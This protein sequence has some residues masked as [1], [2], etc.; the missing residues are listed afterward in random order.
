MSVGEPDR[1]TSLLCCMHGDYRRSETVCATA[2]GRRGR[3]W[4]LLGRWHK[5]PCQLKLA[6]S[7]GAIVVQAQKVIS[8]GGLSRLRRPRLSDRRRPD[9]LLAFLPLTRQRHAPP[10][11]LRHH[12][13]A[14]LLRLGVEFLD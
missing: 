6:A 1:P 12:I 13:R 11:E 14:F 2:G 8:I 3:R 9:R 7:E 5:L 4:I 10:F